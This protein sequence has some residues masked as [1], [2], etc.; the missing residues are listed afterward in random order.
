M[1]NVER[2]SRTYITLGTGS[3]KMLLSGDLI[4]DEAKRS[5]TLVRS[6]VEKLVLPTACHPPLHK[7]R[8]L[9]DQQ[10]ETLKA[11][12]ELYHCFMLKKKCFKRYLECKC[13]PNINFLRELWSW[14]F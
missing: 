6:Q 8:Y 3:R 11:I 5:I 13:L 1:E 9:G 10:A 12:L 2:K 4:I 14:K 7:L